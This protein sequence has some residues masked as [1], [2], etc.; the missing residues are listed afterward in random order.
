M[1][2]LGVQGITHMP[3]EAYGDTCELPPADWRSLTPPTTTPGA[4][5]MDSA[6]EKPTDGSKLTAAGFS[7]VSGTSFVDQSIE[8]MEWEV[9]VG[10]A[11]IGRD[12]SCSWWQESSRKFQARDCVSPYWMDTT[13]GEGGNWKWKAPKTLPA[14]TYRVVARVVTRY[15]NEPIEEGNSVEFRIVK[16][17]RG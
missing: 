2:N 15:G 17:R 16:A 14:G 6:I 9:H 3:V 12:Q 8:E 1:L 13:I 4:L 11:A 10:L 7:V 5:A